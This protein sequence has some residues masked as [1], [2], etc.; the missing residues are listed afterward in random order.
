VLHRVRD[1]GE[2]EFHLRRDGPIQDDVVG[3]DL[4]A[5]RLPDCVLAAG[6]P[7]WPR[8]LATGEHGDSVAGG[9]V[10][11]LECLHLHTSNGIDRMRRRPSGK[12]VPAH[13]SGFRLASLIE[14]NMVDLDR[15]QLVRGGR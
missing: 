12:A 11:R 5:G 4:C 9:L 15:H 10:N 14:V 13:G 1:F 7:A 8:T 3:V 2:E 6:T